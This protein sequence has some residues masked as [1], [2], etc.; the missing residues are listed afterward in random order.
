MYDKMFIAKYLAIITF[1]EVK[2]MPIKL[3]NNLF[4]KQLFNSG[5][6]CNAGYNSNFKYPEILHF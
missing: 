4:Q 2:L 3:M 1:F 6:V 5:Y